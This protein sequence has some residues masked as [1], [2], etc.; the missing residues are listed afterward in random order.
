MQSSLQH[1]DPHAD[2]HDAIAAQ[3]RDLAPRVTD[4]NLGTPGIVPEEPP[5]FPRE[6]SFHTEPLNDNV[7]DILGTASRSKLRRGFLLVTV[8]IGIATAVAWHVYGD[9]AKQQLSQL[10]PSSLVPAQAA[11]TDAQS[12][13]SQ[14]A[15]PQSA[16]DPAP[17][18]ITSTTSSETAA[19]S[20]AVPT[21]AQTTPIAAQ[22]VLPPEAAQ[23]IESMTRE[24]A[25]LKQIVEQLQ[26]GQQQ[27]SR[28]VA[29]ISEQ[30]ARRKLVPKPAPKPQAQAQRPLAP[31]VVSQRPPAPYPA[32]PAQ[33]YPQGQV[34][35]QGSAPRDA[36]IPPATPAQLPPQPG[37]TSAPRPPMPLR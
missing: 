29:K 21:T 17:A 16:T 8:C 18:Q 5:E 6:P 27:L 35:S 23:S 30:E 11:A 12:A 22:T 36:Y 7:G 31:P 28:D 3:L 33:A 34:Y 13:S 1:A 14:T 32:H 20:P 19:T 9:I 24:I 10:R 37:D 25:S 26:S 15:V 2:P 4:N